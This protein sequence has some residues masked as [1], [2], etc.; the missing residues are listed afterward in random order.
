MLTIKYHIPGQFPQ[1]AVR[2]LTEHCP[3]IDA[4][5]FVSKIEGAELISYT[6]HTAEGEREYQCSK[7]K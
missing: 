7:R 4:M 5:D 3:L 1:T 2:F 6:V